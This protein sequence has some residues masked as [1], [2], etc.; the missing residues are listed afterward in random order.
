MGFLDG[1]AS[2]FGSIVG[3]PVDAFEKLTGLDDDQPDAPFAAPKKEK[4]STRFFT[5]DT[6][7]FASEVGAGSIFDTPLNQNFNGLAAPGFSFISQLWANEQ[8]RAENASNVLNK[9]FHPLFEI[10]FPSFLNEPYEGV[11]QRFSSPTF[12]VDISMGLLSK[13]V[14]LHDKKHGFQGVQQFFGGKPAAYQGAYGDFTETHFDIAPNDPLVM[15]LVNY[16]Y[17]AATGRVLSIRLITANGKDS[18]WLGDASHEDTFVAVHT[19]AGGYSDGHL[20][21]RM[22][23][24]SIDVATEGM[25]EKNHHIPRFIVTRHTF[26]FTAHLKVHTETRQDIGDGE[27]AAPKTHRVWSYRNRTTKDQSIELFEEVSNTISHTVTNSD[28]DSVSSTVG[29]SLSVGAMFD[30]ISMSSSKTNSKTITHSHTSSDSYTTSTKTTRMLSFPIIIP[31]KSE[32]RASL[33]S[34]EWMQSMDATVKIEYHDF[35]DSPA[36]YNVTIS[37]VNTIEYGVD[38]EFST[39]VDE[40]D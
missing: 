28:T 33:V 4:H 14:V 18:G 23:I 39:D 11:A 15:V 37:G 27:D 7:F 24:Y 36:I 40:D 10:G 13:V 25:S 30:G 35:P 8:Q 34:S 9:V 26:P 2:A 6:R 29:T 17:A 12:N 1:M 32:V 5:I 22:P 31:A 3:A 21:R 19:A 38:S 16:M 20:D